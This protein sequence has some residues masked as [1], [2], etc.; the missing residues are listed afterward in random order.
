MRPVDLDEEQIALRAEIR[1][2]VPVLTGS[3]RRVCYVQTNGIERT[4]LVCAREMWRTLRALR[5]LDIV[6]IEGA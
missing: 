6:S 5:G 3:R 1:G 2:P 4:I